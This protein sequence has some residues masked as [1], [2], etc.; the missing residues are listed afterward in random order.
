MNITPKEFAQKYNLSEKDYL[1]AAAEGWTIS[2]AI[3]ALSSL[4]RIARDEA[5]Q[6][7]PSDVREMT[8]LMRSLMRFMSDQL[9]EMDNAMTDDMLTYK[10][11]KSQLSVEK[12]SSDQLRWIL[13]TSS[14][15]EDID[16]EI[17][18]EKALQADC[19]QMALTGD[20]GE[21]F[22]WHCDGEMHLGEKEV[23]IKLPVGACDFSMVSN[24][25][26][27]ESGTFYDQEV[28]QKVLEKANKLG[29]SKSFWHTAPQDNVYHS[30]RT[31]ERS[32]MFRPK[33][34]NFLTRLFNG[35]K[36]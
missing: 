18:S 32:I 36:E 23:R 34:S 24:K 11:V 14:A 27:I 15:F 35:S 28:G 1:Y 3:E 17:V 8:T 4:N 16:G 20:Y 29:A 10:E 25:I 26:N 31:K 30:I 22:W 33:E 9:D 5:Y 6:D 7:E 21:L 19:D 13:F 12:D 2:N